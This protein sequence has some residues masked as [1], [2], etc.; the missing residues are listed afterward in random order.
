MNNGQKL[1]VA[2]EAIKK[3][4]LRQ[5]GEDEHPA[6]HA[7]TLQGI[8]MEA[9][10]AMG[11]ICVATELRKI[12]GIQTVAYDLGFRD[13]KRAAAPDAGA[14]T[15]ERIAEIKTWRERMQAAGHSWIK[16]SRP[17]EI[18]MDAV[19]CRPCTPGGRRIYAVDGKPA[20]V[21]MTQMTA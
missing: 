19:W 10:Q 18:F 3:I 15:S 2:I 17:Q 1:A 9:L 11:P 21:P 6:Q 4:T 12:V 16:P 13:D 8:A 7:I 20:S 14:L 5:R